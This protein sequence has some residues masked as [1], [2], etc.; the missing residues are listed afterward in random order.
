MEDSLAFM[1]SYVQVSCSVESMRAK[2][3]ESQGA[4]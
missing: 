3:G 2:I 1:Q 4:V